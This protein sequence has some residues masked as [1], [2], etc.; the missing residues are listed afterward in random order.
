MHTCDGR[1]DRVARG[2][3][4]ADAALNARRDFGNVAHVQD[5]TRDMWS[6][7]GSIG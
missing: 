2:E 4:P 5:V 3:S 7:R 1:A 6:A